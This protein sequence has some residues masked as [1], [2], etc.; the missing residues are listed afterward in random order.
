[1]KTMP[2]YNNKVSYYDYDYD[3]NTII[4]SDGDNNEIGWI[5][6]DKEKKFKSQFG[7]AKYPIN[8]QHEQHVFQFVSTRSNERKFDEFEIMSHSASK[9]QHKKIKIRHRKHQMYK[10]LEDNAN[11]NHYQINSDVLSVSEYTQYL[12][13]YHYHYFQ[14]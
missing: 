10:I 11:I 1:M 8:V 4:M 12:Y 7:T 2:Q 9:Y 6:T 5:S 14:G 3:N 13:N